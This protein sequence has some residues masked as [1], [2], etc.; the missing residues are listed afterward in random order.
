MLFRI[1]VLF[2]SLILV[3]Q[4]EEI[5]DYLLYDTPMGDDYARVNSPHVSSKLTTRIN[6]GYSPTPYVS[7]STTTG[8]ILD[9]Y[10]EHLGHFKCG[11]T[12]VIRNSSTTRVFP[13]N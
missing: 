6:M 7:M 11:R 5:P 13:K 2:F 1:L 3:A 8:E 10:I 4:A 9:P 12:K